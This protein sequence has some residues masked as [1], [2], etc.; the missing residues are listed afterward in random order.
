MHTQ[1]TQIMEPKYTKKLFLGECYFHI[2]I[3]KCTPNIQINDFELHML[4][5]EM[6]KKKLILA[7][8]GV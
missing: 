3:G 5:K 8:F 1:D 4:L 2:N 7:S 6:E